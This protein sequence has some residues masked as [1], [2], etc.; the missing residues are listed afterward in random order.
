MANESEKLIGLKF[1]TS[2]GK[3]RLY[4][5]RSLGPSDGFGV[6]NRY[7]RVFLAIRFGTRDSAWDYLRQSTLADVQALEA[8]PP[9]AEC[10]LPGHEIFSRR[11]YG[12][13]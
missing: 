12:L 1:D 2:I 11:V 3:L 8:V 10:G 7:N 13:F 9:G 5:V 6:L 4:T